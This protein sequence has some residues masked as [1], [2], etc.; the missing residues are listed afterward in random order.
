MFRDEDR[1]R[2]SEKRLD[3]DVSSWSKSICTYKATSTWLK[4]TGTHQEP[5]HERKTWPALGSFFSKKKKIPQ[6]EIWSRTE[7]GMGPEDHC[8]H[9]RITETESEILATADLR[10]EIPKLN[11]DDEAALVTVDVARARAYF[12]RAC[13]RE[14][15]SRSRSVYKT[16]WFIARASLQVLKEPD[17]LFIVAR[18]DEPQKPIRAEQFRGWKSADWVPVRK[19]GC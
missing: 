6:A 1:Q 16:S 15:N 12:R 17:A 13:H 19:R 9:G 3:K 8:G 18:S 2:K 11:I 10:R 5:F 4:S 14:G 7:R